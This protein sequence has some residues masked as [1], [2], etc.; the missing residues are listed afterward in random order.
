MLEKKSEVS[1]KSKTKRKQDQ[2]K[3]GRKGTQEKFHAC[4]F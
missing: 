2:K 3:A 1:E 4:E